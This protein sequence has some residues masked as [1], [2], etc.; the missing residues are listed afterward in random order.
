LGRVACQEG[1]YPSARSHFEE[2]RQLA[3]EAGDRSGVMDILSALGELARSEQNYQQAQIFYEEG[4]LLARELGAEY[5]IAVFL[6]GLGYVSLHYKDYQRAI[7]LLNDGLQYWQKQNMRQRMAG[8]LA[9]LAGAAVAL[10]EIERAAQLLR[11]VDALMKEKDSYLLPP[12]QLVYEHSVSAAR[13]YLGEE[14]YRV[15][16]VQA[17]NITLEQVIQFTLRDCIDHLSP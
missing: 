8:N 17:D 6:Q 14:R 4:L 16:Q 7:E 3:K 2:S 1:D 9:G 15:I 5:A 10:G 13:K 12:N 11:K